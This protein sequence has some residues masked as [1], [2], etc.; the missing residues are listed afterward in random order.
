MTYLINSTHMEFI[1]DFLLCDNSTCFFEVPFYGGRGRNFLLPGT[2]WSGANTCCKIRKCD[3]NDL[4]LGIT[5]KFI[6]TNCELNKGL[7]GIL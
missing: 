2:K 7:C 6:K 4:S 3:S 5:E 1:V